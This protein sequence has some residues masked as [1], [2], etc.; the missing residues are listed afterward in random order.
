MGIYI[1]TS[2]NKGKTEEL[3]AKHVAKKLDSLVAFQSVPSC[4]VLVRVV[5]NGPFEAA[6]IIFDRGEYDAIASEIKAGDSRPTH[7][8]LMN[9]RKAYELAGYPYPEDKNTMSQS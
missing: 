8:L 9:K 7:F 1:Q 5:S 3:I 4:D 6:G 2:S